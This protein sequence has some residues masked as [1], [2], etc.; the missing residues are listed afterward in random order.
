[1]VWTEENW[2]ELKLVWVDGYAPEYNE[3]L[4][5]AQGLDRNFIR[6]EDIDKNE[7]YKSVIS[8]TK[9]RLL[10]EYLDEGFDQIKK[11]NTFY[12][13]SNNMRSELPITNIIS[14]ELNRGNYL[15]DNYS[16]II[17][18][19]EIP[20]NNLIDKIDI[21]YKKVL[22]EFEFK[23]REKHTYENIDLFQKVCKDILYRMGDYYQVP[24]NLCGELLE[25][26]GFSSDSCEA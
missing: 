25:K 20:S 7:L 5:K 10:N 16:H 24:G 12:F 13:S 1:M 21:I 14:E 26:L 3:V 23:I 18:T 15:G 6:N 17:F 11:I 19:A 8:L 2:D 4:R 9:Y 22:D